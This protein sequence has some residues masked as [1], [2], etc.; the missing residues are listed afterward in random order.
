MNMQSSIEAIERGRAS[1][2]AV[3]EALKMLL[4]QPLKKKSKSP[5]LYR[6]VIEFIHAKPNDELDRNHI[7]FL[8]FVESDVGGKVPVPIQTKS[9]ELGA[10]RFEH[11]RKKFRWGPIQVVIVNASDTLVDVLAKVVKALEKGFNILRTEISRM[12]WHNR[13][14]NASWKLSWSE[15]HSRRAE[16]WCP[17]SGA[18]QMCH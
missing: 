4:G 17:R 8:V 6:R 16:Q 5:S 10:H 7:D 11:R 9:S 13:E 14:S 15:R 2:A 18:A 12:L 3:Q 1:E